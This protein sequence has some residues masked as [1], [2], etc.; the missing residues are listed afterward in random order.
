MEWSVSNPKVKAQ[1]RLVNDDTAN[2][3]NKRKKNTEEEKRKKKKMKVDQRYKEGRKIR[4]EL[5]VE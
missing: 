1:I 2:P 3:N 5:Q 4:T